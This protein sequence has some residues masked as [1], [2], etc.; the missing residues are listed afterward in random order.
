MRQGKVTCV[1]ACSN[2]Y[3]P[4]IKYS[5]S[6][7]SRAEGHGNIQD[8]AMQFSYLNFEGTL[9]KHSSYLFLCICLVFIDRI[10]ISYRVN[11]QHRPGMGGGEEQWENSRIKMSAIYAQLDTVLLC[12]VLSVDMCV[13]IS[14]ATSA[15]P[16][17]IV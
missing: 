7:E 9:K 13:E 8:Q 5:Y 4:C 14:S 15:L 16:L 2:I 10:I 12:W 6:H 3:I 11:L 17:L 1:I